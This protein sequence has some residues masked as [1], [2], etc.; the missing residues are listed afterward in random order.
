[1]TCGIMPLQPINQ[2]ELEKNS[3]LAIEHGKPH[4]VKSK[5]CL[6]K[7]SPGL[8]LKDSKMNDCQGPIS[9]FYLNAK[10]SISCK[11]LVKAIMVK[12]YSESELPSFLNSPNFSAIVG[13]L[14]I[15]FL[16]VKSSA[17][18]FA[19]RRLFSEPSSASFVF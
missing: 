13:L 3:R 15:N 14:L 6:L 10:T 9:T 11:F 4:L 17:L 2:K 8:K 12:Y 18:L 16:I 19:K 5:D 7:K 1:M